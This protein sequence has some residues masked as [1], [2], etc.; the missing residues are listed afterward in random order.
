[1]NKLTRFFHDHPL[2]LERHLVSNSLLKMSKIKKKKQNWV[3]NAS[4]TFP[5]HH[6]FL[7]RAAPC[8]AVYECAEL[9]IP[10]IAASVGGV[11]DLVHAEDHEEALF[12]PTVG[13][14]GTVHHKLTSSG[15]THPCA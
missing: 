2:S 5:T 1:M 3:S 7:A 9:G 14:M 4:L 11:P 12:E 13:G 8:G 15:V 6:P 10:F